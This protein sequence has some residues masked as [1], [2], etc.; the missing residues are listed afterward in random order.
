M[1]IYFVPTTGEHE[2]VIELGSKAGI[3][4]SFPTTVRD[5]IIE[6]SEHSHAIFGMTTE[7]L[8]T[9]TRHAKQLLVEMPSVVMSVPGI[10]YTA[11]WN[12]AATSFHPLDWTEIES[13][14]SKTGLVAHEIDDLEKRDQGT[15]EQKANAGYRS[16]RQ[17]RAENNSVIDDSTMDEAGD[18][19]LV[20]D[21]TV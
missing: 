16:L 9:L 5:F 10:V 8:M 12:I 19:G 20:D 3:H 11:D 17:Y 6:S 21:N 1:P 18:E 13:K 15:M 14:L 7:S 2:K 4:V